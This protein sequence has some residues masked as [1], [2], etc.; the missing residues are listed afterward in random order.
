MANA[1]ELDD[2]LDLMGDEEQENEDSA[3]LDE[4]AKKKHEAEKDAEEAL[5]EP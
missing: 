4:A 2:E 3:E 5:V 1:D